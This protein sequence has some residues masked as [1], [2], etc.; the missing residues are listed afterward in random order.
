MMKESMMVLEQRTSIDLPVHHQPG[1]FDHAAVHRAPAR[2]YVAHTANDTLDVIDCERDR[3]LHSIAGLTGVAG[4]LVS[5]E[6][7][8]VFTSNRGENTVGIFA[9]DAE[10]ALVKVPVGIGPN[11]LAYDP[12]RNLLLAANVGDPKRPGSYTVSLVDMDKRALVANV[13]VPGRTRWTVFD[14]HQEVFFVNIADPPQIVVIDARHPTQIARVYDVPAA[15]PHGLDLDV[16]QGRLFCACDAGRLVCLEAQSGRVLDERELSGAPDVM[17]LNAKLEHLYVAIGDPGVIDVF[18]SRA[19]EPLETVATE[20]GAHTIAVDSDR[21][22]VY[23]FLPQTHRAAV[24]VD[25]GE[26]RV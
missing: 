11:G 16:A 8:L 25:T 4:A 18:D 5:D 3:Y 6:R 20:R 21:S 24:Y 19:L 17:F 12:G 15:G 22:K 9:P 26:R 23:A 10:E 13:A 14:P 2:L 7:Q 1:G